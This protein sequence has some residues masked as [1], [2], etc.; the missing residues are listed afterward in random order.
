MAK[1]GSAAPLARQIVPAKER[2]LSFGNKWDYAPAPETFDYIK[3]PK[4]HELFIN[5]EFVPPHSGKYFESINPAT[6]EAWQRRV[7]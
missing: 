5:G 3:I 1:A 6:E 7:Q 4:R 2:R